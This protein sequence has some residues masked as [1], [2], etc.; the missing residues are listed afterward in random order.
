MFKNRTILNIPE[1]RK[2]KL[3]LLCGGGCASYAYDYFGSIYKSGCEEDMEK[4]FI[5]ILPIIYGKLIKE[6]KG[7]K[8]YINHFFRM[9]RY[10]DMKLKLFS[11]ILILIIL[12]SSCINCSPQTIIKEKK[13]PD[14]SVKTT[15]IEI[16]ETERPDISLKFSVPY[17]ENVFTLFCILNLAE[18][19]KKEHS[20]YKFHPTAVKIKNDLNN[21]NS[22]IVEKIESDP[23]FKKFDPY[24][25]E[26][27]N[28][29]ISAM[30][31]SKEKFLNRNILIKEFYEEANIH[32]LYLK[33]KDDYEKE[34][35]E[36]RK[37]LPEA[38]KKTRDY[39]RL[40]GPE[41]KEIIFVLNLLGTFPGC[42]TNT[43]NKIYI[44]NSYIENISMGIIHEYTNTLLLITLFH[45]EKNSELIQQSYGL[46]KILQ[47]SGVF[48]GP[49][50]SWTGIVYKSLVHS[51]VIRILLSNNKEEM[52][53]RIQFLEKSGLILV[54]HFCEKLKEYEKKDI[55]FKDFLPEM[56]ST[57]DIEKEKEE[58]IRDNK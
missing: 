1:C 12:L 24:S 9:T 18:S 10:I 13:K 3:A 11:T 37:I 17:N 57:I 56:L 23:D 16:E 53:S 5:K 43:P 27:R 7:N 58:F 26:L 51:I 32:D 47:E 49:Y 21:I 42:Y 19:Y 35:E 41:E 31:L 44:Y 33:Y 45:N 8:Q 29:I 28:H 34:L 22:E 55:K 25:P 39:F 40:E 6:K 30:M 52:Q 14:V 54:R 36:Y 2:C 46:M 15:Q 50:N 20:S 4:L 48:L 38:I